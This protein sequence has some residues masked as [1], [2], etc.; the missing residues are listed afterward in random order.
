VISLGPARASWQ[1]ARGRTLAV[2]LDG[3]VGYIARSL[4]DGKSVRF[5]KIVQHKRRPRASEEL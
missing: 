2:W 3:V 5:K 1:T 4:A